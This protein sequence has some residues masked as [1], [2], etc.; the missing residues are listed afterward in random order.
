MAMKKSDMG[1]NLPVLIVI[2]QGD[3]SR[4]MLV[5][6]Y[7]LFSVIEQDSDAY[8]VSLSNKQTNKYLSVKT[9]FARF[10]SPCP[11]VKFVSHAV[12]LPGLVS[13]PYLRRICQFH[14]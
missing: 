2:V 9:R 13:E 1:L 12:I 10:R 4:Q 8:N 14:Y 6:I 3:L 5:C 11:L 7:P